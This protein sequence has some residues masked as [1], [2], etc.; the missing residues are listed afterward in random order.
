MFELISK[1]ET[2]YLKIPNYQEFK[3]KEVLITITEVNK[4]SKLKNFFEAAGQIEL[5]NI[6]ILK[7][8]DRSIL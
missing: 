6:E 8:R 7:L 4:N 5:D 1:I 3:G 2:E